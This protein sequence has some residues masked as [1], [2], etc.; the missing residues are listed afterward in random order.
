MSGDAATT[1]HRIN[2]K[3]A[4]RNHHQRITVATGVL[5]WGKKLAMSTSTATAPPRK[6]AC[7]FVGG[8]GC[9][10]DATAR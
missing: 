2:A 3:H 4:T 10:D 1:H 7:Q 5:V 6:T 8:N 9:A